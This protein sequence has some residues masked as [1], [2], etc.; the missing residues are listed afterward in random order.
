MTGDEGITAGLDY[1]VE[2]LRGASVA[3]GDATTHGSLGHAFNS[4][5]DELNLVTPERV[6]RQA[7][8]K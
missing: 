1:A 3:F 8:N 2:F 6:R 5:A 4:A 7:A